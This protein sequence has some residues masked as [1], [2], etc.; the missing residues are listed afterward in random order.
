VI[1]LSRVIGKEKH[2]AFGGESEPATDAELAHG[3]VQLLS[4]VFLL[5]DG[6]G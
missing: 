2:R 1:T 3:A 5:I 6:S 4:G